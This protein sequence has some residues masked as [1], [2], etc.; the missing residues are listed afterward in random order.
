MEIDNLKGEI[1]FIDY[2]GLNSQVKLV[3]ANFD[4]DEFK[5]T[6]KQTADLFAKYQMIIH[7]DPPDESGE[8]QGRFVSNDL[9]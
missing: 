9:F 8:R 6:Y 1:I 3:R 5:A 7:K 4:S 2:M